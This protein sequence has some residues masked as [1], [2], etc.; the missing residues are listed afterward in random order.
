[1]SAAR[2]FV[3]GDVHGC[4]DEMDRL[5]DAIRPTADDTICFLGDYVD[6]GPSPARVIDRLVRLR[7]E[8]PACIFLRGNHEDMF[9]AF[10]GYPGRYGDA[11]HWNGGD[12]TLASYGLEGVPGRL[13]AEL[14]PAA[15]LEFLL[16]LQTHAYVGRFFCVHAGVRVTQPLESQDEE[17]LLWIR[18]EFITAPHAFPYTVLF[19]HTPQREIRI[20][21]PY[22]IGLDTGLVYGNRLSCLELSTR[23]L[24]QI[25]RNARTVERRSLAD[26]FAAAG[27]A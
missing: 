13:A 15:H 8:G 26:Q 1:M 21:L 5:L 17:D 20:D 9:L 22:K 10:L 7:R 11:F 23:E 6:R 3:I 18:E 16:S 2:T 19:G 4:I 12:A 24:W 25:A 14:L 27:L